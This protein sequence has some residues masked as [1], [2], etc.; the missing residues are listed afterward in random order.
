MTP[1]GIFIIF[2]LFGLLIIAGMIYSNIAARKRREA[3]FELATRLALILA[4]HTTRGWR[5][6]I[7]F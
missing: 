1:T 6:G 5:M 4:P 7:A 3:L 2:G